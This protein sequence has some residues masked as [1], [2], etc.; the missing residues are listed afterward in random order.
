VCVCCT[1]TYSQA[2]EPCMGACQMQ[3]NV[4]VL[5]KVCAVPVRGCNRVRAGV[6]SRPVV[7]QVRT[8]GLCWQ[9]PGILGCSMLQLGV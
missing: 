3:H 9:L 6:T 4:R 2:K 8:W 7:M 1:G 5:I